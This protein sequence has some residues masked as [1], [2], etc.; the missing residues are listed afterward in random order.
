MR[1]AYILSIVVL[2]ALVFSINNAY[3]Q[4]QCIEPD[5]F[6]KLIEKSKL[7]VVDLFVV[8]IRGP[9]KGTGF[10]VKDDNSDFWIITNRHVVIGAV[11]VIEATTASGKILKAEIVRISKQADLALLKIIDNPLANNLEAKKELEA[12]ELNPD[13]ARSGVRVGEWVLVIGNPHGLGGSCS[14]G[15]VS[16]LNRLIRTPEINYPHEYIQIDVA[17]NRGNSGGPLIDLDGKVIGVV[18]ILSGIG[19]GNAIPAYIVA[20]ELERAKNGN[21]QSGWLGI[22]FCSADSELLQDYGHAPDVKGFMI[23]RIATDGPAAKIRPGL[24]QG[25]IITHINDQPATNF[26]DA[27]ELKRKLLNL[28]AGKKVTLTIVKPGEDPVN[29]TII[30]GTK[31]ENVKGLY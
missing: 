23:T 12:L 6:I 27:N 11:G 24:K 26:E 25:D 5:T 30:A 1:K 4:R 10:I 17:I 22:S 20:D 29:I 31:P 18:T 13:K 14:I 2:L 7:A 3:A 9:M 19:I 28:T 16:A 15:I 8:M 21:G